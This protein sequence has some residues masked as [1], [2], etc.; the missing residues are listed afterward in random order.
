MDRQDRWTD[1]GP[2][3]DPTLREKAAIWP[4]FGGWEQ[5]SSAAEVTARLDATGNCPE[6]G[7]GW[8]LQVLLRHP[9]LGSTAGTHT[10]GAMVAPGRWHGGAGAP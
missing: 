1:K 9:V 6:S 10:L 2:G 5:A 4:V 3:E 8:N 7:L